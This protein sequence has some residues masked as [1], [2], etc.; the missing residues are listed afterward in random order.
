MAGALQNAPPLTSSNQ[1]YAIETLCTLFEKWKLLAPPALQNESRAVHFPRA[2][3]PPSPCSLPNMT[4]APNCTNNHFHA[5][6]TDNNHDTLGATTWSPPPLLALVQ[7]TPVKHAQGT[8]FQQAMPKRLVFDDVASPSVPI[9][10]PLPRVSKTP[11]PVAHCTRSHLAPLQYSSLMELVQH[12]IPTAKTTWP[13]NTFASQFAGIC[14]A[15]VLSAPET[16]EFACLCARLSGLDKEHSLAV[17][18]Q[19]S[20]QL[21]EHRQLQPMLQRSLGPLLI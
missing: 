18:D 14:Q 2:S 5:L 20:G 7:Q 9:L 10:T 12:H 15:L 6:E 11:S 19:E 3:P 4:P 16:T 17:L 13:Q 21:L 8:H 1:L